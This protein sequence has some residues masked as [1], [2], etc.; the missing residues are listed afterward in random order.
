MRNNKW[1]KY[2]GKY[3]KNLKTGPFF[4]GELSDTMTAIALVG[5]DGEDY[6]GLLKLDD[7]SELCE[8][9][10]G[11]IKYLGSDFAFVIDGDKYKIYD[12]NGVLQY[13]IDSE[14]VLHIYSKNNALVFA[15]NTQM[16]I[17]SDG[18]MKTLQVLVSD[19]IN[20]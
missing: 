14:D 15:Y 6:V 18:S 11:S 4:S 9:I 20:Y 17:F 19:D 10:H 16:E 8:P 2:V 12:N 5:A 7:L 1:S 3:H 13:E